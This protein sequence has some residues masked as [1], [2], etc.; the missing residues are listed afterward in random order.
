ME[1][2]GGDRWS[3]G[4]QLLGKAKAIG[5]ST[6]VEWP[7]PDSAPRKLVLYATKAPDYGML[8]FSVNG[9][10][11]PMFFD[12]YASS[13]QPA[14]AFHLGVF[15]PRD[16]KFTLRI[17]TLPANPAATGARHFFGL[18]CVVMEKP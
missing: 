4:R 14:P 1:P 16:G 2:F 11:V 18:D 3:N 12:G 13:V 7:A 15:S 8:Q 10:E 6:V 5:D 9:Q 17:Y